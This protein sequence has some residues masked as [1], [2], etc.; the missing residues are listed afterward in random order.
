[1]GKTNDIERR[2]AEHRHISAKHSKRVSYIHNA[3]RKY[4]LEEF[5]FQLLEKCDSEDEAFLAEVDWVKALCSNHK[6]KGFNLDSGGLGG[7]RLSE[8]TKA[9]MSASLKIRP[10]EFREKIAAS[11]RGQK[12][13]VEARERMSLAAKNGKTGKCGKP[14]TEERRIAMALQAKNISPERRARISAGTKAGQARK[15]AKDSESIL[16]SDSLT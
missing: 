3:L 8:E 9:K 13:S 7:R 4:G 5:R 11:N 2:W 15:R 12:R 6:D 14:W 16:L 10:K 1:M